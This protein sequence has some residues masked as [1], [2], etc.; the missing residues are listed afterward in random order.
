MNS[1]LALGARQRQILDDILR[2]HA[3]RPCRVWAFGSRAQNAAKPY[4]DLDLA[5][6][7][8]RPLT[9]AEMA[10]L[11]WAFE[12][13]D[14]PWRVDLLDLASCSDSFRREVVSH[15][16]AVFECKVS[17]RLGVGS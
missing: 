6:D 8:G 1:A 14:L 7:A 16:V 4:S 3:P 5:I 9:L 11:A 17:P 10:D 12:E 13:S 15:A 2:D